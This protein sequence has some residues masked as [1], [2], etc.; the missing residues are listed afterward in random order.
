METTLLESFKEAAIRAHN[1]TSF[2][3][4]K[5]GEQLIKD[6]SAQ[7]SED[8]E[9]LQ[10]A[11]IEQE[12]IK[13]YKTRYINLFSSWLA[14][15][16]RCI[17]SMITGPARFPVRK[18]EKANRS[19]ENHYNIWQ[20]WRKRAKKAIIR[21]AQPAK[22][23][24]SEIE[25]YKAEM[26]DMQKNHILMKE[27][28]KRIKEAHKSGEDITEYLINTFGIQ[29]HMIEW[30]MKFGFGLANNNAN[31][32]RVEQRI[33]ELSAKEVA[34]QTNPETDY[35]FEGGEVVFNYEADRIQVKH[36]QKP[37]PDKIQELKKH[38]YKWSPFN[39]VWQRQLTANSIY[40]TKNLFKSL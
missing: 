12:I 4:E 30:T 1:W 21:K 20:E 36:D 2:S 35:K 37:E 23:Y 29:P 13:G 5:R 15:K 3:P 34:R 9:E 40:V 27:G 16:S 33:K 32:K 14:S 22:T 11:G 38:G 39:K 24:L 18:A 26:E 19:E 8:I 25:R 17:S 10:I 7:L 31:M 6:Y 28:N